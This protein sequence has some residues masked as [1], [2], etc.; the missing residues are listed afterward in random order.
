MNF[1]I[2]AP[3]LSFATIERYSGMVAILICFACLVAPTV[4]L[5]TNHKSETI[6]QSTLRNSRARKVVYYG[7]IVGAFFQALFLG[8]LQKHFSMPL[9]SIGPLLYLSTSV[10]T[11][12]SA[13]SYGKYPNV[14]YGV[15]V[16]YFIF[17][18]VSV[19]LI[20]YSVEPNYPTLFLF[21]L[22]TSLLYAL[23]QLGILVKYRRGNAFMEIWAFFVLAVWTSVMTFS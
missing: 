8:F 20:S 16:Y 21:S 13:L 7:L 17:C 15:G 14:H 19:F 10:A 22:A 1:S 2:F 4:V 9:F 6:T 11:I 18:P 23:G 5:R 3:L 12:L